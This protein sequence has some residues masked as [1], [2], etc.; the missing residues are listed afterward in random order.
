MND[1]NRVIVNTIAQYIKT[2]VNICLSL[3]S[4]RLLLSSLG[5]SDYGI[6]TLVAGVVH[7]LSFAINALVVTT[8]RYMSFYNGQGDISKLKEIFSNSIII[9]IILGI[10]VAIIVEVVG[11]FIFDGFLNITLNRIHAAKIVYHFVVLILILSFLTA[12]FRALLISH[13]NIVYVSFIDVIDGFL[14]I[15]IVLCVSLLNVDRLILYS[16]LLCIIQIVELLAFVLYDVHHYPECIFPKKK[17]INKSYIKDIS[18]FAGWTIFSVGCITGRSQGVSIILNRFIGVVANA[19][20]G[21]ALQVNGAMSFL[22]Q[23]LLNALNPQIMKAEGGNNRGRMLRLAEIESK[24]SF[25]LIAMV[26]IPCI[27]EMD[28]ILLVWLGTVPVDASMFCRFILLATLIDQM[29]IGLGTANQAIGNIKLYSLT[30]NTIKFLTLIPFTISLLFKFGVFAAMIVYVIL[31]LLCALMR[32]AFLKKTAGLLISEF[33]RKVFLKEIVPI[34]SV[35]IACNIITYS[36][37]CDYRFLLTIATSVII[38]IV[39]VC[40]TGLCEDEK[41]IIGDII[42]KVVK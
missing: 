18:A 7:L 21:V 22:S 38:M 8:Q 31:E 10:L 40:Y 24:F 33:V 9:H 2:I 19:A 26:A 29:T 12:P 20:Y 1:A 27:F 35:C 25:L 3:Y 37:S 5:V 11:F 30:I 6:Y 14:K 17:Y 15:A 36:L 13:E 32:L 34:L 28:N 4:T 41:Q 42:N 23:S 16:G 39:S